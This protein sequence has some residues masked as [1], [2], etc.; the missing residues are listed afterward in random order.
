MLGNIDARKC[1][2]VRPEGPG[3]LATHSLYPPEKPYR[4]LGIGAM[5]DENVSN[6]KNGYSNNP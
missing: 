6:K 4:G 5:S 3:E 2:T 1:G